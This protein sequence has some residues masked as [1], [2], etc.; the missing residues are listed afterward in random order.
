MPRGGIPSEVLEHFRRIPL[1]SL[2]SR[3]ALRAVVHAATEVDEPAGK[4]L[5]GEG[6]TDR[7]MFVIT[8]GE[9]V[10]SRG[11]HPVVTLGPGDFFG[12]FALLTGSP[13]SASVIASTDVR[14]MVLSWREMKDVLKQ[15]PR[16]AHPL[17]QAVAK[18]IRQSDR[19]DTL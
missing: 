18:R 7:D 8:R 19:S 17:L 10:V 12:E 11:G 9:A 5:V 13:R 1:F 14:V 16:L 3:S 15:E 2:V 6:E 4:V